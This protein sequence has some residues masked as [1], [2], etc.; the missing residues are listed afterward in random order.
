M[1]AYRTSFILTNDN[2]VSVYSILVAT[3]IGLIILQAPVVL[4]SA[5][6]DET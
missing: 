4:E 5:I 3:S 6:A 2:N 1:N